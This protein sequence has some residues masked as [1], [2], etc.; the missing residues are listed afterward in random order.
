MCGRF[1]SATDADGLTRFM[2]ID[3]RQTP[4]LGPNYNVAPSQQVYAVAE[5]DEQRHLVALQ[6]GLVPSWAK[7]PKIGNRLINARSET[8]AEKNSFKSSLRKR[9][10]LI[11]ADGFYEWQ[12]HADGSKTPHFIHRADGAPMALAGLWSVW[13]G[14][15]GEDAAPLKTCTILTTRANDFMADLHDRMPVILE[16]EAWDL[17]LDRAVED[18]AAVDPLLA[19]ADPRL[20]A[21]HPVSREVNNPRNNH[22]GLIEPV[23]A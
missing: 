4:D 18:P 16:P 21:G 7:D 13:R 17:W 19:P 11:P 22:A 9:R 3:E 1:V 20:L 15:G 12:R 6:W 8:A 2:V 23:S 10:C 14:D 5:H